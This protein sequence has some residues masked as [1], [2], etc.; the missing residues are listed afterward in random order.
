METADFFNKEFGASRISRLMF[1]YIFVTFAI[2]MD[3][4]SDEKMT[5]LMDC[6]ETQFRNKYPNIA[7]DMFAIWNREKP[8]SLVLVNHEVVWNDFKEILKHNAVE[9]GGKL[10]D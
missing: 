6:A 8:K 2:D 3:N 1:E 9:F 4:V 5:E 10:W 7:E